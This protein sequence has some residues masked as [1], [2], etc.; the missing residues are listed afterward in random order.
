MVWYVTG[1]V[2]ATAVHLVLPVSVQPTWY[3]LVAL[4]AA[5]PIGLALRQTAP[6]DKL[7]GRLLLLAQLVL[8]AGNLAAVLDAAGGGT[9]HGPAELLITLGHVCALGSALTIV[10]R[11]GRND[12]GGLVDATLFAMAVGGVLWTT[13]IQ[14]RLAAGGIPVGRQVTVLVNILVLTG[15]L[16]ALVRLLVTAREPLPALRRYIYALVLS[17]TGNVALALSK[18]FLTADRPVWVQMTFLLT[19]TCLGAAALDPSIQTLLRPGPAPVDRLT[20]GRLAF[21]GAALAITPILGGGRQLLGLPVDGLLLVGSTL[22]VVPLV[23]VRIGVLNAER[24]RALRAL[25]HQAT[26]D[27]LT[28]LPNRTE[29]MNRLRAAL[30]GDTRVVLLFCDLDGF[31]AINDRL[32][33]LAGDEL[34]VQVAERLAGCRGTGDT[35]ARY[36]GDEFVMVCGESAAEVTIRRAMSRPFTVCGEQVAVGASVGVVTARRGTDAEALLRQADAA[37]YAA[38][39]ARSIVGTREGVDR[40]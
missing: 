2:V 11:R 23:M 14:P 13:M 38:K 35:L 40:S 17:L 28:G 39:R 9:Q 5:A 26:H 32:G 33:H 36:G 19:Y 12:I 34:L 25:T 24:A 4:G 1:S 29:L 10:R 30:R 18:G 20:R 7:P 37:M 27:G 8:S 15:I 22:A 3:F 16:G 6:A 21:L 31:K